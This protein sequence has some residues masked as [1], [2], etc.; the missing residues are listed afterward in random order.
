VCGKK[1]GE[2]GVGENQLEKEFY[3]HISPDAVS[4][5]F[6]GYDV[7]KNKIKQ[8]YDKGIRPGNE[9]E[10]PD[11]GDF[12]LDKAAILRE[13]DSVIWERSRCQPPNSTTLPSKMTI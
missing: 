12:H 7:T 2:T 4:Q 11:K 13:I 1:L 10:H 6:P 8:R 9:T 5:I 3:R